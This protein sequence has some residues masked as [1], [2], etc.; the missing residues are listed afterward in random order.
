MS[1][2]FVFN[3]EQLRAAGERFV[4]DG[5]AATRAQRQAEVDGALNFL[6]SDAAT[7]LRPTKLVYPPPRTERIGVPVLTPAGEEDQRDA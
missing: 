6:L 7:K 2:S 3:I 4:A 5:P 1:T